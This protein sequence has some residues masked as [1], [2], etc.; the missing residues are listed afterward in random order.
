M[1]DARWVAL[2][3]C[4]MATVHAS[5]CVSMSRLQSLYTLVICLGDRAAAARRC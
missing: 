2:H 5:P 3:T 4:C 1:L